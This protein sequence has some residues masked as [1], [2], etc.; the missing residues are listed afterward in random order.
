[1]LVRE[2]IEMLQKHNPDAVLRFSVANDAS[3]DETD[4]WFAEDGI[5][6]CFGNG[7]PELALSNETEVTVCLVV[8][9][10]Q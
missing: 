4:R 2:M 7:Y 5:S 9:P 8:E 3:E 1:M 10:N 6:D